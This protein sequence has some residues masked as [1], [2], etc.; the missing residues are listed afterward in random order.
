M[1]RARKINIGSGGF[2]LDGFENW[3]RKTGQ[4]AFPLGVEDGEC[5][6]IRA[7]HILEHFPHQQVLDVLKDWH[8]ALMPGGLLRVSVPNFDTIARAYLKN[9]PGVPFQSYVM[10][11]QADADDYHRALFDYQHLSNLLLQAGFTN[12]IQMPPDANDCAALAI[13]LNVQAEKPFHVCEKVEN[14][15]LCLASA[16]FGPIFHHRTIEECIHKLGLPSA[17]E[18]SCFWHSTQCKLLKRACDMGFKYAVTDDFDSIFSTADVLTLYQMMEAFPDVDA[19]APLQ[20]RRGKIDVPLCTIRDDNF[21]AI[22]HD[23]RR[24]NTSALVP[25]DTAHFGLTIIRLDKLRAMPQPWM[26]HL[27]GDNGEYDAKNGIDADIYFW[28]KWK[29]CGNNLFVAPRVTI[30]HVE[31]VVIWPGRD[32]TKKFQVFQDYIDN[33]IPRDVVRV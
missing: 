13:S 20:Q 28:K 8:R 21:T 22:P 5:E 11:S 15:I 10:G 2:S 12:I 7:S 30:G 19:I 6:V 23:N 29:E 16:R 9:Q 1:R 31:E 26:L 18:I 24:Y 27:P 4:E 14:T 17:T 3:D 25:V 33:G 32:G